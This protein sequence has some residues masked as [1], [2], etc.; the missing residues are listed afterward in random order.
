MNEPHAIFAAA[1]KV[2]VGRDLVEM[3]KTRARGAPL[4]R[5]RYCLHRTTDDPLQ[6]MVICVTRGCYFSPHR[7]PAW[8][9]KTYHVIEGEV[10]TILFADDGRVTEIVRLGLTAECHVIHRLALPVWHTIVAISEVAVYHECLS[11]PFRKDADDEIAPW[12]PRPDDTAGVER[13]LGE[14]ERLCA[15]VGTPTQP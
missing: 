4:R 10:A 11:G 13:F 7:H 3:V 2:A 5:F 15:V 9:S 8:K 12:A 1:G 14:L 6:E